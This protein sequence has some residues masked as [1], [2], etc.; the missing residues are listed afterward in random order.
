MTALTLMMRVFVLALQK[1]ISVMGPQTKKQKIPKKYVPV[2]SVK[3]NVSVGSEV[4]EE[5]VYTDI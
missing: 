3:E 5:V 4:K 1:V 2:Y